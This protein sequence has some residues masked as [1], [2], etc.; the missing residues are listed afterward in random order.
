MKT[1]SLLLLS[2]ALLSFA[3]ARAEEPFVA[4]ARERGIAVVSHTVPTEFAIGDF[5]V[6]LRIR[7]EGELA[8][9]GSFD[10]VFVEAPAGLR[11]GPFL[12]QALGLAGSVLFVVAAGATPRRE[13][14][15][16][17]ILSGVFQGRATGTPVALLA[18]SPSLTKGDHLHFELW[19][20]GRPADPA[21][22]ISF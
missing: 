3:A 13:A 5:S 12:E 1:T 11:G 17:K 10:D 9:R 20:N 21:E 7:N 15:R 18:S 22:Y 8:L 2:A 16:V 14:D 6:S 4:A 19:Y